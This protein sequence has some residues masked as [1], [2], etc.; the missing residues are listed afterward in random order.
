MNTRSGDTGNSD[1]QEATDSGV[2]VLK[3]RSMVVDAEGTGPGFAARRDLRITRMGRLIRRTRIARTATVRQRVS[4]RNE[5]GRATTQ[6][7][8]NR[9]RSER[10]IL[11]FSTALPRRPGYIEWTQ[12]RHEHAN[13]IA[14]F[15]EK[16]T[17]HLYSMKYRSATVDFLILWKPARTHFLLEGFLRA[18]GRRRPHGDLPDGEQGLAR[19]GRSRFHWIEL[20]PLG[21]REPTGSSDRRPRQ[22]DLCRQSRKST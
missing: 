21:P 6:T 12:I 9:E 11:L 2:D 17:L 7:A 16:M 13:E 8:E 1:C 18:Y 10:A 20:R 4:W 3:P 19:Y 5:P 15:E 14:A 22:V